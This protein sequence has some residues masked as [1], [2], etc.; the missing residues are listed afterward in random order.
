MSFDIIIMF[1]GLCSAGFSCAAFLLHICNDLAIGGE[2]KGLA[3]DALAAVFQCGFNHKGKTAAAG[4]L[5]PGDC[6]AA[7][8]IISENLR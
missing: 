7:N 8:I 1:G 6:D 3:G 5:H 4:D 2:H